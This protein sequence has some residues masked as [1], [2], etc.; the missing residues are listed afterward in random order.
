MPPTL[1]PKNAAPTATLSH[2]RD[3]INITGGRVSS[4]E[5][6][7][8]ANKLTQLANI[9]NV[10][11][12]QPSHIFSLWDSTKAPEA[13]TVEVDNQTLTD[14]QRVAKIGDALEKSIIE[15]VNF[16]E[17]KPILNIILLPDALASRESYTNYTA[18]F[19]HS[20]SNA[21]SH[22]PFIKVLYDKA[23]SRLGIFCRQ[24]K[25]TSNSFARQ[26]SLSLH[27]HRNVFI[28]DKDVPKTYQTNFAML[29]QHLKADFPNLQ[30]S[31]SQGGINLTS[32]QN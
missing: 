23:T 20:I 19:A 18:Q 14:L 1:Q 26:L 4:T 12:F 28:S 15:L 11:I 29:R 8:L 6:R 30:I 10:A 5:A 25:F 21:Q 31:R 24:N 17:D 3:Y 13:F 16:Y 27:K 2:T 32:S 7:D 9:C 22:H